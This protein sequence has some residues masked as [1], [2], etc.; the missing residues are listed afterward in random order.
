MT[1]TTSSTPI[2]SAEP[3]QGIDLR[4]ILRILHYWAWLLLLGALIGAGLGYAASIQSLPIYQTEVLLLIEETRSLSNADLTLAG[5]TS[6]YLELI[7]QGL[8][9]EKVAQ[10]L[11]VDFT[12]LADTITDMRVESIRNTQLFRV[13][14]EGYHPEYLVAVANILPRVLSDEITNVRT[15]RFAESRKNL[16]NQ[17]EA[18]KAQIE[19][20]QSNMDRLGTPRNTQ[21]ENQ[22]RDLQTVLAQQQ[23][24][25]ANLVQSF[26]NLRLVELQ[27]MD[28]IATVRSAQLPKAPISGN[29]IPNILL[30]SLIGIALVLTVITLIEYLDDRVRSPHLLQESLGTT[31]L[32]AIDVIRTQ[33][34]NSN[35]SE[36]LI[37]AVEPRHPVS[38]A[39]RSIRTNLRF[40]AID[41]RLRTLIVTSS[42]AGEGKSV[43][44]AN[45]AIVMAQLGLSVV[46][47]DADTRK[48]TQHKLFHLQK[49]PGL[50]EALLA[51]DTEPQQYLREV[52]V[53]NLR[54]LPSGMTPPNPAELLSSQRMRQLITDL[55]N[56]ADVVILDTP[57]LLVV[58]DA[59]VLA[60]YVRDIILVV[61]AKRTQRSAL[62][63]SVENVRKIDANIRGVI[64]N[65]LSRSS[66]GYSY[67]GE[68]YANHNAKYYGNAD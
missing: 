30:G 7:N 62:T 15:E 64:V 6:T 10:V 53:P 29:T 61:N 35:L 44:A 28:N 13:Y 66:R 42:V 41:S 25:Y 56:H 46:L 3:S 17:I 9:L 63:R 27:A 20:T 67:Y 14:V 33:S 49:Q 16:T 24:S 22:L 38:E 18:I 37:T 47:V 12:Q 2:L 50:S 54:L 60:S 32:G 34:S 65:E 59:A 45:L 21:Q 43:T 1:I 55:H 23:N 4:T 26:E 58:T 48:P 52:D 31:F 39:Y 68:Y 57:P 8:M 19:V 5:R 11:K 40:S 36:K 51:E